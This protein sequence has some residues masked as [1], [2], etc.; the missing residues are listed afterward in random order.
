MS[1]EQ[2]LAERR[3]KIVVMC[4]LELR[5]I[6]A[7]QATAAL[8]PFFSSAAGGTPAIIP[9]S[10]GGQTSRMMLQGFADQV[11][12]AI[13]LLRRL[14]VPGESPPPGVAQVVQELGHRVSSLEK[15]VESLENR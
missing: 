12:E 2:V 1:P 11:A 6:D 9:G 3:K 4:D 10:V 13:E 14:D 15:R 5:N 7:Q 8:R